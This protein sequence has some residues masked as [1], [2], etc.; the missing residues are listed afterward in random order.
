MNLKQYKKVLMS[1]PIY[2]RDWKFVTKKYNATRSKVDWKHRYG[3]NSYYS[4]VV[5]RR[6]SR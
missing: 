4:N 5:V 2:L 6:Y 1:K 3:L